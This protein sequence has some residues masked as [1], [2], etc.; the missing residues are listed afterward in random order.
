MRTFLRTVC[1]FLLISFVLFPAH[2]FSAQF[3]CEVLSV[4]GLA[5]ATNPEVGDRGLKSGDLLKQG[6]EVSVGDDSYVDLAYDKEWQNV[7]RLGSNTRIKIASVMPGKLDLKNGTLF[8]KLKKLPRDSEF[9]VKTPTAVASVRG[10]EYLTKHVKGHTE[11][12]NTSASPIF[13]YGFKS[14]GSIDKDTEVVLETAKKTSIQKAGQ[15]PAP[16]AVMTEEEQGAGET[17]TKAIQKNIEK[18]EGEGRKANIQTVE[19]IEAFIKETKE[20]SA[21]R[22]TAPPNESELSRVTDTRRRAFGG[23]KA[24]APPETEPTSEEPSKEENV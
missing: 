12:L 1:S 11:V 8:A 24:L 6:D 4:K 3:Q 13:V 15:A 10:T 2:A 20:E 19:E 14:D 23:Q 21:S 18:A 5:I 17:L 16:P 22:V 7:T 9:E